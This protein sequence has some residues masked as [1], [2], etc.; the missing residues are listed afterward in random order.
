MAAAMAKL[1]ASDHV[2]PTNISLRHAFTLHV[3]LQAP[4]MVGTT[5]LGERRVI[6][7]VGGHFAGERLRGR[8]LAGGA[9]WNVVRPDGV[10]HVWARYEIETDDGA[11]VSVLNEGLIRVTLEQVARLD[12]GQPSAI[13]RWYARTSPR[14]ETAAPRY[15]WLNEAVFIGDLHPPKTP[16]AVTID[17]HEVL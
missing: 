5:Y 4:V 8:V 12:A 6:P 15:R 13:D 14:F 7:I 11:V 3:E 16:A 9:D 1:W 10:M 17:V 2:A